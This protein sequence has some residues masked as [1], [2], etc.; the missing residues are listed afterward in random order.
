MSE[1]FFNDLGQVSPKYIEHAQATGGSP[2]ER[3]EPDG[4]TVVRELDVAWADRLSMV[5]ILLGYPRVVVVPDAVSTAIVVAKYISRANPISYGELAD[6]QGNPYLF[7]TRVDSSGMKP[8]TK[9]A[10]GVGT[11]KTSRLTCTFSSLPWEIISDAAMRTGGFGGSSLFSSPSGPVNVV[12]ESCLLRNVTKRATGAAEQLTVQAGSYLF[13][14]T[15]HLL[16]PPVNQGTNRSFQTINLQLT[17][18]GVPR[19][20]VPCGLI[21]TN[22]GSTVGYIEGTLGKLNS[23][24]FAGF[25]PGTLLYLSCEL[26]PNTSPLGDRLYDITHGFKG[27][28]VPLGQFG[29]GQTKN[30]LNAWATFTHIYKANLPRAL[31]AP[32][33]VANWYEVSTDGA[34]NLV[35]QLDNKSVYN[36]AEMRSLFRPQ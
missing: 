4:A 8:L 17:W 20:G 35:A 15:G 1:T 28:L 26:R 10:S 9:S 12:D 24:L 11:Y 22:L 18:H 13:V 7:C 2:R 27:I 16:P 3:F 31:F 23:T 19:S 33:A 21:N 14:A 32:N 29:A 5:R 34:T 6:P 25:P 36:F 30:L